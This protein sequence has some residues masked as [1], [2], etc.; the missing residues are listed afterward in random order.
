MSTPTPAK[1]VVVLGAGVAGV[2]VAQAL[3]KKLN[4]SQYNLILVD[5]RPHMIWLP[6]GA[7]M[8]VS[9]DETFTDTVCLSPSGIL[10]QKFL[11]PF[12]R[13]YS[14]T[15][16]SS[17]QGRGLSSRYMTFPQ[18]SDCS[19]WEAGQSRDDQRGR[20]PARWSTCV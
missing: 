1:N 17:H 3:S 11:T 8:V 7:R 14:H 15:T 6:A 13:L 2:A 10:N 9:H 20:G 19:N 16:R 4:H 12:R 18:L 5:M